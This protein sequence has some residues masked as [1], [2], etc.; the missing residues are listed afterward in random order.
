MITK[1]RA[2]QRAALSGTDTIIASG[3]E[4][5]IPPLIGE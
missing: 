3:K 5:N 4:S 2:A 1:I